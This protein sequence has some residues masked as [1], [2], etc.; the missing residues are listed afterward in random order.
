MQRP[1]KQPYAAL[2]S[3]MPEISAEASFNLR[4]V[5]KSNCDLITPSS[6]Y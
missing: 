1:E 5:T 6:G 4:S 2:K 3:I